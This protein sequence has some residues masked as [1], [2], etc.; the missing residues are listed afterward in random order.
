MKAWERRS[1]KRAAGIW[2]DPKVE[3]PEVDTMVLGLVDC[4]RDEPPYMTALYDSGNRWLCAI[5]ARQIMGR[6]IGWC[7]M[8]VARKILIRGEQ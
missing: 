7:P 6:V 2:R 8:D 4:G 5:S 3:R 1:K